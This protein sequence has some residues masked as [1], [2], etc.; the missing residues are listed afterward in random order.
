MDQQDFDLSESNYSMSKHSRDGR[1]SK[2]SSIHQQR[3][4]S[5]TSTDKGGK[6]EF[7]AF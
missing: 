1:L 2:N 4:R 5:Q 3:Q 7:Y 6:K